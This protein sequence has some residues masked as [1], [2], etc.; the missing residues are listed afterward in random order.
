LSRSILAIV[1]AVLGSLFAAMAL[2][3]ETPLTPSSPADPECVSCSNANCC[4]AGV[5]PS[6][7]TSYLAA[8]SYECNRY[9]NRGFGCGLDGGCDGGCLD[10]DPWRLFGDNRLLQNSNTT[11]T[12]W[13]DAGIMGNSAGPG[14]HFNGPVT[15]P[16]RDNGQLNQFYGVLRRTTDL[17]QNCGWFLGGEVDL[18]FGSDSFFTTAAGLDGTSFGNVPRWNSDPNQRYGWSIPQMYVETDYNNLR[19]KWGH[20]YTILGYETI[21]AIGNFFYTHSYA[22]QYGQP[23]T[24]TGALASSNLGENWS[25][26]AGIVSGWNDF[27]FQDG[28]QFLGGLT[29]TNQGY[30][31][32]AFALVSGN[33]SDF[34]IPGI[35]PSSNRTTYSLVWTRNL[36]SRW[37]Y[38]LH[39]TLGVQSNSL[40]F[41][42]LDSRR[43]AWYGINQY[44]FYTINDRWTAGGRFEWFDD[45]QGYVVT[46]L[47][48]GNT[49]AQFR[50]PGSF[51]EA[52]FGLNYKPSRNFTLRGELR[53]DWYQGPAGFRA[54]AIPGVPPNQPFNDNLSK[55][56]FLFG[57]DAIY[58][59]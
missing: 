31:S 23:F 14:T 15:F 51:Y 50:F 32:L 54:P 38:V 1:A 12:G 13:V 40:G 35:P 24:H 6:C 52:S 26:N 57:L 41:N 37:T 43:A 58:Q 47:R 17:S 33:Q 9:L 5:C 11:L 22:L 25:W 16:D 49:D 53:Y 45:P 42:A 34:N 46:G 30:G 56:Q 59:F 21:P 7:F 4:G 44:L 8:P 28:A 3:D 18:Y 55:N 27:N 36:S 29:Y 39:H 10:A 48:P 20:F 2:A 19:V